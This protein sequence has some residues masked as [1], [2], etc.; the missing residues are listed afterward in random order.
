MP[1]P[2]GHAIAGLCGYTLVARD[3]APRYRKA[4]LLASVAIANLPDIDI[5]PGI[6][7]GDLGRFHRQGTHSLVASLAIG[8]FVGLWVKR[9]KWSSLPWGVWAFT[10]YLSHILLDMLV[11]SSRGVQFFWPFSDDYFILPITIFRS[12]KYSASAIGTIQTIFSFNNTLTVLWEMVLLL[13]IFL[14]VQNFAGRF[15]QFRQSVQ[16]KLAYLFNGKQRR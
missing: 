2:V 5:L 6:F 16:F 3:V 7:A 1:S 12:F 15:R 13:P 9:W 10:L 4:L 8:L 11:E 14:L